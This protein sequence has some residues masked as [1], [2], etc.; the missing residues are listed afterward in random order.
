MQ[1]GSIECDNH[2][3]KDNHSETGF[4]WYVAAEVDKIRECWRA[5]VKSLE[6][7]IKTLEAE[8]CISGKK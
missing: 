2:L 5:R 4:P 8:S 6:A 7:K 3:L 1:I